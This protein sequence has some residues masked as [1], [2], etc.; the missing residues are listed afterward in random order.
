VT[1]P[2]NHRHFP[3]F[4]AGEVE[5][6][7]KL[8]DVRVSAAQEAKKRPM[9]DGVSVVCLQARKR[10]KTEP[11]LAAAPAA[12]ITAVTSAA[13]NAA[14]ASPTPPPLPVL[15]QLPSPSIC[16]QLRCGPANPGQTGILQVLSPPAA[17][18]VSSMPPPPP[19]ILVQAEERVQFATP[20]VA[21]GRALFGRHASLRR[22]T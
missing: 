17:V 9:E 16:P 10:A 2:S 4:K 14:N 18:M 20:M 5:F 22:S 21:S 3:H 15:S 1:A 11:I 6:F 12:A 13:T 19:S 8:N 7:F